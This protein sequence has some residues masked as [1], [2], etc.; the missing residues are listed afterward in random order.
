MLPDT[1]AAY[2]AATSAGVLPIHSAVHARIRLVADRAARIAARL[3][4]ITRIAPE[5]AATTA[6]RFALLG[7]HVVSAVDLLQLNPNHSNHPEFATRAEIQTNLWGMNHAAITRRLAARWRLPIWLAT[8]IGCLTLPLR[9][10]GHLAHRIAIC[11]PWCN[12]PFWKSEA[13]GPTLGSPHGADRTELFNHLQLNEGTM[14][15]LIASLPEAALPPAP[16]SLPADPH[17]VPLIRNLLKLAAESRRRN[18]PAL[19]ARLEE[20]VDQLHNIAADLGGQVGERLR[21]AKLAGL[22]ELAAGAGHEINNPLA[23]ISS[24]A[25]RLLRTEQDPARSESLRS[26]IRQTQRIASILRDLMQF[27]RPTR[28]EPRVFS[29]SGLLQSVHADLTPLAGERGVQFDLGN[30][31]PEVELHGDPS[32]IRHAILAVTRNA[33]EA[34]CAGGWVRVGCCVPGEAGEV[35]IAVEDS[36]P[37]L[38]PEVVAHAFDPFYSGR[39]AGRG[40]GLGLP[41]AWQLMRQNGGSIRHD[42]TPEGSTRFVLTA[43][44]GLAPEFLS[45][46]SA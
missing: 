29:L 23:V 22:A 3:S 43:R 1:A 14:R 27:A 16:S 6:A 44:R 2:L 8:T 30:V 45:L 13:I 32:Q 36:G 39:S 40:R 33:I 24:N 31:P 5:N 15:D 9:V 34:A 17:R 42:S 19:V 12:W 4:E 25:Q 35:A 46:R 37:G 20:H 21:D 10:S 41:T 38:T 26:V 11:S 28:P 18:G 7:W